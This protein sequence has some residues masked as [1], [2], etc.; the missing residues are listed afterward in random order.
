MSTEREG[1]RGIEGAC[2][3]DQMWGHWLKTRTHKYEE[4]L[5]FCKVEKKL[6]SPSHGMPMCKKAQGVG[7]V[8]GG[9][10]IL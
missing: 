3:L 10:C 6:E 4:F 1:L 8:V 9:R 7:G 5:P 2:T